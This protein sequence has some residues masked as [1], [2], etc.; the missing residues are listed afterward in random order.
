MQQVE[1]IIGAVRTDG[2]GKPLFPA[3]NFSS[4]FE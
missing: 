1:E 3:I 2:A 4:G